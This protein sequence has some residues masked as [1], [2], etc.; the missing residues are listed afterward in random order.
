[1][2]KY[3]LFLV[4]AMLATV[5]R[6]ADGDTFTYEGLNFK[7][8]SEEDHTAAV[9]YNEHI[10][11]DLTIPSTVKHGESSYTVTE[12]G[13]KAFS[14]C[15]SLKSVS[16][17]NSVTSIE[18][19][20][21][22]YCEN[23]TSVT[24]P[25]SVTEIGKKSFNACRS[26]KSVTIPNS[27]TSIGASAF[28]GCESLTS[29][30][31]P[32]SV[33]SIGKLAFVGC[34]NMTEYIVENGNPNYT[35]ENGI[36]FNIDKTTIIN[37]PGT[38]T[39]EYSIPNSVTSIEAYAFEYCENLSSVTIP[40]SMTSIGLGAFSGCKNLSSINIPNSVTSIGKFAFISCVSLS[41]VNIPNLVTEIGEGT[42]SGCKNLSSINIP[43]SVTSIGASAFYGC[44][45]LTSV[46][47]PNSVT[48]IGM[49]AFQYCYS[50]T[51][52]T[53]PNSV[54]T[55]GAYA[56][57]YCENLTSVT[58]QN[59]VTSIGEYA[60][61]ACQSLTSVT[62]PNSVTSIGN[63]AFSGCKSLTSVTIP[64]SVTTIGVYA[65]SNCYNMTE[66]LIENGNPNYASE[67]GVLFNVD[68]TRLIQCPGG[69]TGEYTIPNSVTS[70]GLGAFQGCRNITSFSIPNSVTEI[71][72]STFSFCDNLTSVSIP[73]S[74][75]KI[76]QYAFSNDVNLKTIYDKNPTPQTIEKDAFSDVPKDVVV[77]IPKGSL[78]KY[79]EA[80]GWNYFTDFREMG[81]LDIALS[82]QNLKLNVGETTSITAIVTKDGEISVASQEWT[83]SAPEVATVEK[84]VITAVATGEAEIMLN[85]IDNFGRQH[86]KACTVTV[87]KSSAIAE[88][89]TDADT[90]VDVYNLQGVAVLRGAA[91]S[92]LHK[93][94]AGT[95]IMRQGKD[96]KKVAVK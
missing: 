4:A 8:I 87:S 88:V 1:M 91:A 94:P 96:I 26:L 68:K 80:E 29:I 67:D 84:G 37:Y 78:N 21:F 66:I 5:A 92:A 34:R 82:Y 69:K 54:T 44:E 42:F 6:A 41:S 7:V 20:A 45:S 16:I 13:E 43:N 15:K 48:E 72:T 10:S 24:I 63:Y 22:E 65:F 60:F 49:Y 50:L 47:I 12:I 40:N 25:N 74:V 30:T 46:T 64:N 23:L 35:S 11:G 18:A 77:Y 52:V 62:I 59:S 71:E 85:I 83:S 73:A 90:S 31:I 57:E 14:C 93:L 33:T 27:V 51:S 79:S 17:P 19:Y 55:I 9:D 76:G 95:Y 75:T 56:F 89:D 81:T 86:T 39:G 3:L 53:I 32:S 2:K 70:I 28:Y 58:I 38:K 36:L 61:N